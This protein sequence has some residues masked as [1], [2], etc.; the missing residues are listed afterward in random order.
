MALTVR[1][2]AVIAF[3]TLSQSSPLESPHPDKV[4]IEEDYAEPNLQ[5]SD[6]T[7]SYQIHHPQIPLDFQLPSVERN[8]V[9]FNAPEPLTYLNAPRQVQEPDYY[10]VP[11]PNQDL[12]A[13]AETEWN[14]NNDPRLYYEVPIALTKQEVPTKQFPKKFIED[15]H[16]KTKPFAARPKQELVLQP[17]DQKQF[18]QRQRDLQKR[19]EQLAKKE[20]QEYNKMRKGEQTPVEPTQVEPET[21][22]TGFSDQEESAS[23]DQGLSSDI[24]SSLGIPASSQGGSSPGERLDF[25]MVGHDGPLSYKWGFDTGKGHNRQFRFEERDKEGIVKGHYGYY[26]KQGK[27]K[28]VNYGAHPKNGFHA[29]SAESNTEKS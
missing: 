18:E 27:L 26:D 24:I 11:I 22:G 21:A 28:M 5:P 19:F 14:P 6:A 12:V 16:L 20:N 9:P 8:P 3:A 1:L 23:Y 4:N 17:I 13:P 2:V 10:Q 25:H 7:D 15:I 29:E